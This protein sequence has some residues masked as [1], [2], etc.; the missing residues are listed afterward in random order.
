MILVIYRL[1]NNIPF[2]CKLIKWIMAEQ[3]QAFL[4]E[5]R[6]LDLI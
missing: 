3:L 4:E 1:A 2:L 5:T 6:C